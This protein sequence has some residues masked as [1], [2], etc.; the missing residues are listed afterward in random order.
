MKGKINNFLI[1]S[2]T[3][4]V[5]IIATIFILYFSGNDMF[6]RLVAAVFA[7]FSVYEFFNVTDTM[8]HEGFFVLMM[9]AAVVLP[10]VRIPYYKTVLAIAF[11][12]ACIVSVCMMLYKNRFHFGQPT[13]PSM[14]SAVVILFFIA[15]P[16]LRAMENGLYY[17]LCSILI[18]TTTDIA[19]YLIGKK[20]GKTKLIPAVSPNKTVEGAVAGIIVSF[21]F[22]VACGVVLQ[23]TLG[24]IV[25]WKIYVQYALLTSA[26]GQFGDLTA[27]IIKR[28]ANV[29]DYGIILPGHGGFLDRLDS[30]AFCFAFT[31][32]FCAFGGTFLI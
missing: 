22:A 29:K 17:L 31:Y 20:W 5:I 24:M 4:A 15:I 11:I 8:E 32:L 26:I 30:H 10:F 25:N 7:S 1:R 3:T 12:L 19:A 9:I 2:I 13:T 14:L 23:Y 18:C 6:I 21:I 16:E 27:S 28:I